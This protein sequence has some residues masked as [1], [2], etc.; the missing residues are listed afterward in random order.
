M[1]DLKDSVNK[2][3]ENNTDVTAGMLGVPESERSNLLQWSR[4]VDVDDEFAG[5]TRTQ[6]GD[7]LHSRPAVL[8]YGGTAD[9]PNSVIFVGTNEGYLHAINSEDGK[10]VFA[11][12]P[13][14][15]LSNLDAYYKNERTINRVYGLDGD[16]TLW[17]RDINYDGAVVKDDG[18]RAYLYMGMRRGG[19]NYT[20]LDVTT[21]NDPKFLWSIN[22]DDTG[23]EKLGQSWSKP[24]LGRIAV[25]GVHKNVL[26]FAG[27][28][29][30][31]QD[32]A[33]FRSSDPIGNDL[34]I[35]DAND[36]TLLWN[37]AKKSDDF[38]A[39]EYSIPSDPRVIDMNGDG[40][41]DQIYVGDMGGQVWRLDID[42]NATTDDPSVSGG[43][44]ANLAGDDAVNN[45]RF[46][47]APDVALVSDGTRQFLSVSIGSGNRAH[48]LDTT[49]DDRFY[50]IRQ[51]SLFKA[52]EGYGIKDEDDKYRAITE[53]DL[54]DATGNLINS[55]DV[56]IANKEVDK[57]NKEDGWLLSLSVGGEK[58][59][60]PSV[61]LNNN[62]VFTTY[63][64]EQTAN[65]DCS[66]ATGGGRM[67]SVSVLNATPTTGLTKDDRFDPLLSSGIPAEP[68]PHIDEDG[69]LRIVIGYEDKALP[70]VKLVRR[71]YWTEQP[72]Y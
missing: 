35:V 56:T 29:N 43:V 50:M 1:K 51:H 63:I 18:D 20:A 14:E 16:L 32:N 30:P 55:T 46:F 53:D 23:F 70:S 21:K 6:M 71:V 36:G 72:D 5:D 68:T 42:N 54:Y 22:S 61:T 28:Y 17:V 10:E 4:G 7:P 8:T 33:N 49:V 3:H 12:V 69:N 64:P 11:F 34:F 31:M 58:V 52:P 40:L 59:L 57:L 38:A 13:P 37:T 60:A 67:Y 2:L 41:V 25:N 48:P 44:I 39:M 15:L 26:I 65:D 24:T 47:Y 9:T 66:P 62:V 45:R 19:R 27:G